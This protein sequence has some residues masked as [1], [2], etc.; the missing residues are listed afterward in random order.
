VGFSVAGIHRTY[1]TRLCVQNKMIFML[2]FIINKT[3]VFQPEVTDAANKTEPVT[4]IGKT[5]FYG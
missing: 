5:I 1:E 2:F 4:P 3:F